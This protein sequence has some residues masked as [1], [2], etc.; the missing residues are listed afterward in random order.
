MPYSLP[1]KV[2]FGTHYAG[3]SSV[4]YSIYDDIGT[5]IEP[6][7]TTGVAELSAEPGS[8][9][10]TIEFPVPFSGE[11]RWDIG[12][13]NPLTASGFVTYRDFTANEPSVP[14]AYPILPLVSGFHS[15][16]NLNSPIK[17]YVDLAKRVKR[18]L[19]WPTVN[20]EVCDENIYEYINQALEWYTK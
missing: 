13:I 9:L 1:S 17:S 11:I 6:K 18:L 5:L 8:Y 12:G 10:A 20:I 15:G 16:T 3:L 14:T 2:V 4:G 19:G 7:T